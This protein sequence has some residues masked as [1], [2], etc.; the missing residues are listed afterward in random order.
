MSNFEVQTRGGVSGGELN[1]FPSLRLAEDFANLPKNE[2]WKISF[3]LPEG[4]RIRLVRNR[5]GEFVM[6]NIDLRQIDNH[7]KNMVDRPKD[8]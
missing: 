8:K 3:S 1:F 6:D 7:Y 4:E 2:V 5:S